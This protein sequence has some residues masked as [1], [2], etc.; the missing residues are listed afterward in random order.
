MRSFRG[1]TLALITGASVLIASASADAKNVY[2][3]ET[4]EG[5]VSFTDELKRVPERYRDQVKQIDTKTLSSVKRFSKMAEPA[6]AAHAG[7]V[8]A[9]LEALRALNEEGSSDAA[10]EMPEGSS[11]ATVD[12]F[13][14]S[15]LRRDGTRMRSVVDVMPTL[16]LGAVENE[17]P[18]VVEE[19]RVRSDSGSP[20]VT[21]RVTVIRQGDKVLAV[22]KPHARRHYGMDLPDE[23]EVESER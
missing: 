9:R 14:L 1:V 2:R 13:S 12:G 23:S 19:I 8:E 7:Q 21:R 16:N 11:A 22:V 3:W 15:G 17:A 5:V 4:E 18:I 6:E 20:N 10:L